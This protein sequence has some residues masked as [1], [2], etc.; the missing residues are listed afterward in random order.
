MNTLITQ[1]LKHAQTQESLL[2]SY[3]AKIFKATEKAF[4]KGEANLEFLIDAAKYLLDCSV[5]ILEDE[6]AAREHYLEFNCLL[7]GVEA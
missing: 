4:S 2:I 3:A 6:S 5:Q 1:T 7:T